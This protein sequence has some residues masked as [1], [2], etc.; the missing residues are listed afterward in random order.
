MLAAVKVF[1][2]GAIEDIAQQIKTLFSFERPPGIEF[3]QLLVCEM[4][5]LEGNEASQALVKELMDSMLKAYQKIHTSNHVEYIKLALISTVYLSQQS[6]SI[7]GSNRKLQL[8]KLSEHADVINLINN[9]HM[10]DYLIELVWAGKES[11]YEK[12][13]HQDQSQSS[14]F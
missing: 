2:S 5:V 3:A 1:D 12:N 13:R 8:Q 4:V 9:V 10:L 11:V 6:S 7:K 14:A